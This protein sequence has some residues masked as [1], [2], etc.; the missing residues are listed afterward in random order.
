MPEVDYSVTSIADVP[1]AASFAKIFDRMLDLAED[2]VASPVTASVDAYEDGTFRIK[3]YHHRPPDEKEM[4]YYH[5]DEGRVLYGR[6]NDERII[7]M[8]EVE[9]IEPAVGSER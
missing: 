5:S 4:L 8:R 1:R 7:I 6:E 2:H 3:I 9:R